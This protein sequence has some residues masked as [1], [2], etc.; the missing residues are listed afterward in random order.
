MHDFSICARSA[1]YIQ[2]VAVVCIYSACYIHPHPFIPIFPIWRQRFESLA[3]FHAIN[4]MRRGEDRASETRSK[5]K[6]EQ[7]MLCD[8]MMM[9]Q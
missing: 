1:T 7:T 5:R 6:P 4:G 3:D 8:M 9:V 2:F